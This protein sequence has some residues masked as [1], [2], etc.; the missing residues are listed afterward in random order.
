[1]SRVGA[2]G[3]HDTEPIVS[4]SSSY[5]TRLTLNR[6]PKGAYVTLPAIVHTPTS[7][8]LGSPFHALSAELPRKHTL[9]PVS[10]SYYVSVSLDFI[11][12]CTLELCLYG[13]WNKSPL[14]LLSTWLHT[15]RSD[16]TLIKISFKYDGHRMLMSVTWKE[17]S[18]LSNKVEYS[19]C[20]GTFSANFLSLSFAH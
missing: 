15:F 7:F 13:L 17:I 11:S 4:F 19:N 6:D 3:H 10:W 16:R 2:R 8:H 14:I 12:T 1:M 9:T 18:T 5:S 20:K